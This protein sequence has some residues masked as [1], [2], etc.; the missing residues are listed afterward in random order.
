M[1]LVEALAVERYVDRLGYPRDF[2]LAAL[3]E[4]D[5]IISEAA[6]AASKQFANSSAPGEAGHSEGQSIATES[7]PSSAA[8]P[9][10]PS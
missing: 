5:R 4:A 7:E 1:T 9:A 3:R 2:E 8:A 6:R 10:I